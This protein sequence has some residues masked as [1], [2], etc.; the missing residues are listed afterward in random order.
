MDWCSDA[1]DNRVMPT[2]T[3][4]EFDEQLDTAGLRSWSALA[5]PQARH[6]Q[7]LQTEVR[8]LLADLEQHLGEP[9]PVDEGHLWDMAMD[10]QADAHRVTLTLD[11]TGSD[12]LAACLSD[13]HSA[14]NIS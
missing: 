11:L 8:E 3:Y 2:L 5:S 13:W 9:G 10:T 6:V 14:S 1:C 7:A 4:L 12:A